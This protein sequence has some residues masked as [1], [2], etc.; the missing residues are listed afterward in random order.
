MAKRKS[1][2]MSAFNKWVGS[3]PREEHFQLTA[4]AATT[5]LQYVDIDTN[6]LDGYAWALYGVDWTIQDHSTYVSTILAT[7]TF[8]SMT[9][10]VHRNDD[11]TD[12]IDYTDDDLWI[13][14]SIE[15]STSTQGGNRIDQPFSISKP[16]VTFGG[17]LRVLFDTDTDVTNIADGNL[18]NGTIYYDIIKAPS[19]AQ[20]KLGYLGEL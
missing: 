16:S 3:I 18:I 1:S 14:Q 15:F 6:L 7:T 8:Q 11:H 5:T 9:L 12:L 2:G 4:P 13:H 10:Q 19:A 17:T 20:T